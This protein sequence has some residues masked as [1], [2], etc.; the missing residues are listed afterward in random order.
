MMKRFLRQL[1]IAIACFGPALALIAIVLAMA[2]SA[3]GGTLPPSAL[4]VDPLQETRQCGEP[5]RLADGS[6][7]RRSDVLTAYRKAHPCPATGL[8]TGA[9]PG[10]ALDH[11]VTLACGGCDAVSNLAWMPNVIKSGPGA[12][13]KDRWERKV[14][15]VPATPAPMPASGVLQL[16][17]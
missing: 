16:V 11:I 5:V 3:R 14:Y 15:C 17:Q 4:Q 13:P 7:R 10:W 1:I 2:D 8:T 6:I 9:C 12:F